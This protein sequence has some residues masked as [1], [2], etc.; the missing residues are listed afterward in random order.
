MKKILYIDDN[1]S[2]TKLFAMLGKEHNFMAFIANTQKKGYEIALSE[3]PDVILI[4][5][6]MADKNGF[7]FTARIKV[8]RELSYIPVVGCSVTYENMGEKMA[9]VGGIRFVNDKPS[10]IEKLN[11]ILAGI[12]PPIK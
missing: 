6:N 5:I 11:K 2:L 3:K 7:D 4:D 1:P 10:S 12:L 9:L 8:D